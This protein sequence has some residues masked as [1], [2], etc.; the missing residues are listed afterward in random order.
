MMNTVAFIFARGDS[1]GL[2]EKNIRLFF[3]KP[4][5][6]H[7]ITQAIESNLFSD[8]ADPEQSRTIKSCQHQICNISI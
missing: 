5:I 6:A 1:K 8:I 7:T 4:L 3:D 2:L